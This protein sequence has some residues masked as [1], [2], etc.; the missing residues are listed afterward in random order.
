MLVY[1][2]ATVVFHKRTP[3]ITI[4]GSA[5]TK[6]GHRHYQLTE[7]LSALLAQNGYFIMT[8]GG[9]GLMEA[10]NKGAFDFQ[11]SLGCGIK[12]PNEQSLNTYLN[13]SYSCPYFFVRKVILVK[14]SCAF[15]AL[16]GGFGTLDEIF[17]VITL[18]QTEKMPNTPIVLM[19]RAYW[20][21]LIDFIQSTLIKN[22]TVS[23]NDIRNIYLVDTLE[24]VLETM[25]KHTSQ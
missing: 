14:F 2:R 21:P 13:H 23:P 3:C 25:Q 24:E 5:R 10:A 11:K 22:N 12:I 7:S 9:P 15:I 6:P 20:Q 19:D 4:W 17:E 16:P 18:T 1:C 8:G